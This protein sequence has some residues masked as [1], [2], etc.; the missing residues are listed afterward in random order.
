MN[1]VM[2]NIRTLQ[3]TALN[4]VTNAVRHCPTPS[5][6]LPPLEGLLLTVGTN[7]ARPERPAGYDL[8]R[9]DIVRQ[10]QEDLLHPGPGGHHAIVGAEA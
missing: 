7:N 4:A 9:L 5:S 10:T 2:H 3:H 8:L 6:I 1:D